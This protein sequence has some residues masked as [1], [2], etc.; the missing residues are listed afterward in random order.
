MN[1]SREEM[2]EWSQLGL[3]FPIIYIWKPTSWI[4]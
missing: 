2:N 4:C 1:G 3:L